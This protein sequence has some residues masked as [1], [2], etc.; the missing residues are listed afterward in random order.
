M[1]YTCNDIL[2]HSLYMLHFSS[3]EMIH[4]AFEVSYK[5]CL[6][7]FVPDA[8]GNFGNIKKYFVKVLRYFKDDEMIK[9]WT[10]FS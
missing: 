1:N 6:S 7:I 8:Y 9:T 3:K 4:M 2:S 5:A 10:L